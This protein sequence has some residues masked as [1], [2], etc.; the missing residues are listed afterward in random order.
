MVT[1]LYVHLRLLQYSVKQDIAYMNTTG[2]L[3]F[4]LKPYSYSSIDIYL[5]SLITR[6]S[7]IFII[8]SCF[9]LMDNPIVFGKPSCQKYG[10]IAYQIEW[11]AFYLPNWYPFHHFG[12]R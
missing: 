6:Y 11:S 10:E 9:I 4:I 8:I 3:L 2:Y 12:T 1:L 5:F 7:L